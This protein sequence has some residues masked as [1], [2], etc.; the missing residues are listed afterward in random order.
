MMHLMA[1][2]KLPIIL[3]ARSTLGTLNHSLLSIEALRNR[4]LNLHSLVMV[5]ENESN[6]LSLERLADIS[7]FTFPHFNH[8]EEE[9]HQFSTEQGREFFWQ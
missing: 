5:G 1:Q 2:L 8:P 9:F 6:R 3:V 7:I 4:Q